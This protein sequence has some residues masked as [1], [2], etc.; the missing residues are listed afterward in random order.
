MKVCVFA[1]NL[2][3]SAISANAGATLIVF[4]DRAAWQSAVDGPTLTEDFNGLL[5]QA[6]IL[7]TND[8]GLIDIELFDQAGANV[9]DD[10]SGGNSIDGSVFWNGNVDAFGSPSSAAVVSGPILGFGADWI[11]TTTGGGL[12]VLVGTD[13]LNFAD[14]LSGDGDGFLGVVADAPFSQIIFDTVS[15]SPEQF[16]LDNFSF[17]TVPEPVTITLLLAGVAAIAGV[18]LKRGRP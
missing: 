10:G 17:A 2:L 15:G 6:L 14:H 11:S 4:S 8:A 18:R 12:T 13:L 9:I 3:L 16:G 7:G 5:P 1:I